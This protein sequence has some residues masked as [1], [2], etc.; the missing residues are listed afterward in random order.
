MPKQM[1]LARPVDWLSQAQ[2]HADPVTA[3]SSSVPP[4][5]KHCPVRLVQLLG[6]VRRK[7]MPLARQVD[8][9]SQ[10][11]PNVDPDTAQS[12]SVPSGSRH[13][14][15]RLVQLLGPARRKQM[16]LARQVDWLSQAQPDADP[17]HKQKQKC[18]HRG[19]VCKPAE[20]LWNL[21]CNCHLFQGGA[22]VDLHVIVL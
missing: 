2:P 21:H 19:I 3:Q 10:A 11:R 9:L 5:S 15:V 13:C 18:Y 14:L 22:K 8:W 17:E 7:Q 20:V 4:G 1:P 12:S 6:P 16:P